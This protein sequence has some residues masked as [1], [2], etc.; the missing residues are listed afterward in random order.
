MNLTVCQNISIKNIKI[1]TMNNSSVFQ[2]G[3]SGVI[4]SLSKMYNTGCFTEPAREPEDIGLP[5]VVL[6]EVKQNDD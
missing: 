2:I 5:L 4:N 1:G 3:S 6:P